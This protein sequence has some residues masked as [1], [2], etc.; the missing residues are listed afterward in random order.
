MLAA[1]TSE[2]SLHVTIWPKPLVF[3][4]LFSFFAAASHSLC[5]KIAVKSNS[6]AQT[7]SLLNTISCKLFVL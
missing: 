2:I 1:F 4:M 5:D 7:K 3:G 6:D